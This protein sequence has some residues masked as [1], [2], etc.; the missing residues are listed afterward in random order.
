[1]SQTFESPVHQTFVATANNPK[2][3]A[4]VARRG[5]LIRLDPRT[6]KPWERTGFRHPKLETW[7]TQQIGELTWSGLVIVQSW[8]V[9]GQPVPADLPAFGSFEAWTRVHGGILAHIGV[10]G[11]LANREQLFEDA[12]AQTGLYRTFLGKWW[13]TFHDD[14]KLAADLVPLAV[15]ADLLDK[16]T[17]TAQALGNLLG[18]LYER[19]IGLDP[20][21]AQ[22]DRPEAVVVQRGKQRG[23]NHWQL[24]PVSY[25]QTANSGAPGTLGAPSEIKTGQKSGAPPG[26]TAP[27]VGALRTAVVHPQEESITRRFTTI[28]GD[29]EIG[30]APK[31]PGVPKNAVYAYEDARQCRACRGELLS[32]AEL[33]RGL[34]AYCLEPVPW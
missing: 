18:E 8:L 13:D 23:R 7:A 6:E 31:A 19:T 21:P 12:D 16:Q 25:V 5:V 17:A 15:E 34:H 2:I 32:E 27:P 28:S 26:S 33:L 30:G 4:E 3:T 29:S 24:K 9:A 10:A 1:M 22:P 14:A 11:F 20:D